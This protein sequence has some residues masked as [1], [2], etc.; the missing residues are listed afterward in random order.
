M[1]RLLRRA[2]NYAP[3]LTPLTAQ[4]RRPGRTWVCYV[5]GAPVVPAFVSDHDQTGDAYRCYR[6]DQL[7]EDAKLLYYAAKLF[8][9]LGGIV[10][11]P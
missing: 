10:P 7:L 8:K 1:Q 9:K 2:A 11:P 6:L 5:R 3:G 4:Y